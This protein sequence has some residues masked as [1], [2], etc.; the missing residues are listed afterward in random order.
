M[1]SDSGDDDTNDTTEENSEFSEISSSS[2]DP[3]NLD[4]I[5]KWLE[6]NKRRA[7]ERET[8]MSHLERVQR[9]N[10]LFADIYERVNDVGNRTGER[11]SGLGSPMRTP[12]A[13][14]T[15][16]TLGVSSTRQDFDAER[17]RPDGSILRSGLRK[18]GDK[19]RNSKHIDQMRGLSGEQTSNSPKAVR[20]NLGPMYTYAR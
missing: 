11:D 7:E 5:L 3:T 6:E 4:D 19:R 12:G 14:S 1:S 2:F 13:S 18:S 20:S 10:R 9:R 17:T 16:H 8:Q 15:I